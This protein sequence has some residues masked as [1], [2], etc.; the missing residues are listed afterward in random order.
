[1]TT[2][3]KYL[4]FF[5]GLSLAAC[6]KELNVLPSTSE[7]D[8]NV[9][10]DT[11][12]ASTVLN[13]VYYRFADA[14]TDYSG[15]PS[16]NWVDVNEGI[17][18]TL[19]GTVDGFYGSDLTTFNF[20]PMS[21]TVEQHWDYGSKLVNAANGF[22]KNVAPVN[23]IPAATK[24]QMIAED[25]FLRAFGN[26]DLLLYY[27]QYYDPT[28]KYGIILR[29]EFV[30]ANNIS[31]PRS[32]VADVYTSILSDLDTAIA[33]LPA[34]NTVSWYANASAAKLLKARVLIN[35]G[36]SGD[37]DE[38]ISLTK[39]IIQNGPFSL[40]PNTRDIFLSKGLDS[41]EIILGV[42]V[43]PNETYKFYQ[44]Q[45]YQT[46]VATDTL[47]SLLSNDPRNQWIYKD[48]GNPYVTINEF[49]KYYTGDPVNASPVPLCENSYAFRLTE[50]YLLEAEAITLVNGDLSQ[51]RTLLT[52]VM[53]HAGIT[54]FSAVDAALSAA[55]LQVLVVK[56]EIRNFVAENGA[57]WLAL[58]RLPLAAIQTIR[59]GI[60][61]ADN[62]ILP[63]PYTET[64]YNNK[65]IQNPGY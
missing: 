41:K 44:Y 3:I 64:L 37:Y 52:T 46:Y 24:K 2:T 43:Y 55:A 10:V 30:D 49:T 47:V 60:Q 38:V 28:S 53:G 34:L 33:G 9:I 54:D 65:M 13:G 45:Y 6:K 11:K 20:D 26:A 15:V 12:S 36:S 56:E 7:V 18:S 22:L 4:L 42:A 29:D 27:G 1:M 39:D 51:A 5:T 50:A 19:C 62:F 14:G 48:G 17:P 31:L 23:N 61:S 35:R 25:R 21:Y 63:I 58:R 59:P 8:G 57:D 32:K 16:L 40:E